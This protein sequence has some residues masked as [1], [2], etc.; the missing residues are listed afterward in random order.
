VGTIDTQLLPLATAYVTDIGMTGP[1]DSV[2]G[3]D[4]EA[5]T[6]RFLTMIPHRLSV[7]KGKVIFNAIV[8]EVDE[9]SGRAIRVDRISREVD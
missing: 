5:V 2:I 9:E 1:L 8:V 7:G 3:D 6:D 4:V